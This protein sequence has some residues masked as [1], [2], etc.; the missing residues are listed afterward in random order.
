MARSYMA[1]ARDSYGG[2]ADTCVLACQTYRG[3]ANESPL[4]DAAT[5]ATLGVVMEHGDSGVP[6]TTEYSAS[7]GGYTV[8]GTF[9]AVV[10]AGDAICPPG[11]AGAE[12]EPHVARERARGEV[13]AAWPQLGT[14]ESITVTARD[15]F[16][17]WGDRVESMTLVGWS[18][19]VVVTVDAFAAA[20]GFPFDW[21]TPTSGLPSAAVAMSATSDGKGYWLGGA[22]GSV[23]FGDA[24]FEGSVG[25]PTAGRADRG[26][27]ATPDGRATGRWPPTAGSSPSAT[28]ASSARPGPCTSTSRS[29]A[30]PPPRRSRLLAGRLRRRNL[31]LR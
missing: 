8:A 13:Q 18:Q 4:T 6:L 15:G 2:Y 31:R 26:L 1:A 17:D 24:T 10:D 11:V 20:L 28:R 19:D 30:W 5:I 25:R 21:F 22:D 14:L 23:A 7:T 9:P 3:L 16:G 12:P 29:S 27:V